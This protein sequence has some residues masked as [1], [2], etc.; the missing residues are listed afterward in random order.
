MTQMSRSG[1]LTAL[2][3]VAVLISLGAFGCE[4]ECST[5]PQGATGQIL[6]RITGGGKPLHAEVVARPVEDSSRAKARAVGGSGSTD[7][8][9]AYVLDVVPGR[10]VLAVYVRDIWCCAAGTV[11]GTMLSYTEA[12]TFLVEHAGESVH[13]DVP[14][15]AVRLR[16][17]VPPQ[18]NGK[19]VQ[20]ILAP[21]EGFGHVYTFADVGGDRLELLF[22][23]VNPG[24]FRMQV[25]TT[26]TGIWLP[27]TYRE[28][29]GD[30]A[31]VEAGKETV[32]EAEVPARGMLYGTVTGSWQQLNMYRPV[33]RLYDA[34]STLVSENTLTWEGLYQLWILAPV[35]VRLN[36]SIEG[37]MAWYGGR[38][39]ADATEFDLRPGDETEVNVVESGI[40]GELG[41]SGIAGYCN[42][43]RAYLHDEQGR[44]IAST[45]VG[46]E[47]GL[48]RFANLQ[49]GTYF[50]R[51]ARGPTWIEHW[52]DHAIEFAQATP[53]EVT[54]QGQI[55][56]ISPTPL[57][58]AKITGRVLDHR[59][60]PIIGAVVGLTASDVY[61]VP[62][63]RQVPTGP[64]GQFSMPA[65][66]DGAYKLGANTLASGIVWYPGV[67]DWDSATVITIENL[68]DVTGIE[69]MYP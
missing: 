23:A 68:T 10:Y 13:V 22:P 43:S 3:A 67:A 50:L 57:D 15:G 44:V 19:N 45:D 24:R 66:P 38:S 25:N 18:L 12:D 5:A 32:Y 55:V 29:D 42:S 21:E 61:Q 2:G 58:G 59:G 49:P 65:L 33:V 31:T 64:N 1:T 54:G 37:S 52:Y 47:K 56:W 34:D 46:W 8:T 62:C 63:E 9:G 36:I 41:R 16:L 26:S 53:I 17:T 4:K 69:I 39:F 30:W 7:S 27:G 11:A 60:V 28:S 6:G 14:L 20:G 40:A 35:R 48:I 51:L